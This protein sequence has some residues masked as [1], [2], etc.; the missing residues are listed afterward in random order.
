MTMCAEVIGTDCGRLLVSEL[1][2]GEEVLV[3][4]NCICRFKKGDKIKI[5]YDGIMTRSI[6]PQI[7]ADRICCCGEKM[8]D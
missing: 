6:P 7:S 3:N 1:P 5:I 2:S 4:A 8:S